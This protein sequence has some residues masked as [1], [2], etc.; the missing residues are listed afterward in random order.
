MLS[1]HFHRRL[2]RRR[3]DDRGVVAVLAAMS[4]VL[5]LTIAALAIDLGNGMVRKRDVHNQADFA[6]LAAA[7]KL[8]GAG[9]SPAT[10]DMAV[11]SAAEY[12]FENQPQDDHI[13]SRQ[14]TKA[15]LQDILTD[16][17]PTNGQ[18]YYGHFVG[19]TLVR[20]PNEIT[21]VTPPRL[22][23]YGF[24]KVIGVSNVEVKASAT[25]GIR[26]PEIGVAPFYAT[27]A[28]GYGQQTLKSNSGGLSIPVTVPKLS[29]DGESNSAHLSGN[30]SPSE[31]PLSST[32][33]SIT[34]PGSGLTGVTEVGFF[35]SD[36]SAPVVQTPTS[37]TANSLVVGVPS[38]VTAIQEVWYLRVK[39]WKLV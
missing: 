12:L 38:A 17:N 22:V 16:S 34:V 18:A 28:C 4:C 35:R 33:Q 19:T 23:E 21:I 8:P 10:G 31:I 3:A 7:S 29:N 20:S 1:R 14:Y 39:G 32:G 13:P 24:A 11:Q 6:A 30:L 9:T 26:S 27:E 37:V 15:Q 25:V 5:I 2:A 36:K